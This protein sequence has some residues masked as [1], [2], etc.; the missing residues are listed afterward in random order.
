MTYIVIEN[1][2]LNSFQ[3]FRDLEDVNLGNFSFGFS[4]NS[5]GRRVDETILN[6]VPIGDIKRPMRRPAAVKKIFSKKYFLSIENDRL[7]PNEKNVTFTFF[8]NYVIGC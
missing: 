5:T 4:L 1:F 8:Q 3:L 7:K 6:N 2:S